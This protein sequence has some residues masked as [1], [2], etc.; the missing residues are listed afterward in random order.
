MIDARGKVAA[1]P[2]SLSLPLIDAMDR[3]VANDHFPIWK[4]PNETFACMR[5]RLKEQRGRRALWKRY[6]KDPGARSCRHLH[7]G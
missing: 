6:S 2:R 7:A 4:R 1:E 5:I 3:I